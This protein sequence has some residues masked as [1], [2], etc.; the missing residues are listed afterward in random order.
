MVRDL[1]AQTG[2]KVVGFDIQQGADFFA[3]TEPWQGDIVTNPPYRDGLAERFV[4]HALNLASGRVC[5][6]MQ[7][8]FMWGGGRGSGLYAEL[9]PDRMI[10]IPERIYF[11]EAG[12]P[13]ESQFYSHAWLCWPDRT[14][15]DRGGYV[16][17]TDWARDF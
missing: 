16:R 15:R 13:I 10:V 8:G 1:R 11:F 5:M 2:L 6:L 4:R 9:K 7:S 12:T 14:I 3:R 17:Q